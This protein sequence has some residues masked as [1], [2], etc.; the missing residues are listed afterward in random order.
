MKFNNFESFVCSLSFFVQPKIFGLAVLLIA[1]CFAGNGK[2]AGVGALDLSFGNRGTASLSLGG[3]LQDGGKV[4]VQPDGKYISASSIQQCEPTCNYNIA[5][6]RYNA[7]G[8]LDT[9]FGTN[10]SVITD[11]LGQEDFVRKVVVQT[12]GKIVVAA[13]AIQTT[14]AANNVHGFRLFRYLPNGTLDLTFGNNGFAIEGFDYALDMFIEPDGKIV[15]A[16]SNLNTSTPVFLMN[17]FNTNGS[18]DTTFGTNGQVILDNQY[19]FS[20]Q[21]ARQ[22]NGKIVVAASSLVSAMK[23]LRYN[24]NGTLDTS[25]GNN[26]VVTSAFNNASIYPTVVVQTDGKIIVSGDFEGGGIYYTGTG[27]PPLRRFNEDGSVDAGF[28]PDHG[29]IAYNGCENCTQRVVKILLSPDGKFYLIGFYAADGAFP[30][31]MAVSRYLN[32]GSIDKSYGFR[33]SSFFNYTNAVIYNTTFLRVSDALLQT[34]GKVVV[35]GSGGSVFAGGGQT[36]FITKLTSTVTP[37]SVRGDFDGDR[38]TDFAVYRPSIRYWFVKNSSDSSFRADNY[39]ADGDVLVPGDYNNDLQTDLAIFRPSS[40]IWHISPSLPSGGGVGTSPFGNSGDIRI[41]ADYDGDG[42]TDLAVFNPSNGVWKIRHSQQISAINYQPV[43]ITVQFGFGTDIPVPADYD[44][45][46]KAD[47][48]V[49]RPSNG[50]WYI[51]QS[52]DGGFRAVQFG[53][54]TDKLVPGDYDGDGKADI[55]VIRDG[56]WY[57]LRSADNSFYG[58][59][60]GF[61]SDKPVPGDYDGDGKLDVAVYRP[62]DG[63]WYIYNSSN[64][65]FKAEL[66]GSSEDAPIP[67]AY[68]R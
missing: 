17:R 31:R 25:F 33:G 29:V 52:S 18:L 27:V 39:G 59:T 62:F 15:V 50:V 8:T 61:G 34:D 22:S 13:G 1:V 9:T 63:A 41:P 37:P 47:I 48:A 30:T 65:S 40:A 4:A 54:G 36:V 23:L 57:M 58:I 68:V 2:A 21:I 3:N 5:L 49:F 14:S 38:K 53:I 35:A 11:H 42:Y 60:W 44:G 55:A 16:G 28:V 7:D 67:F 46:G 10:G 6:T 56:N 20:V 12:D 43:D 19:I 66:F 45:D 32:N 64:G 51:L 26:G 24:S